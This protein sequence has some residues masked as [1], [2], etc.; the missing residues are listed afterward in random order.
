MVWYRL[1]QHAASVL[2]GLGSFVAGCALHLPYEGDANL[3]SPSACSV[4][5]GTGH[6]DPNSNGEQVPS[7]YSAKRCRFRVDRV[8]IVG[9]LGTRQ[10]S[11][12]SEP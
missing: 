11:T 8:K 2:P 10:L 4:I 12:P 1:R 7:E 5:S 9:S 6:A 3:G